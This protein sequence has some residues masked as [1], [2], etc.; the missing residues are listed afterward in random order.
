VIVEILGHKMRWTSGC[1]MVGGEVWSGPE[2]RWCAIKDYEKVQDRFGGEESRYF[3][4]SAN[5]NNT[6]ISPVL[7]TSLA[8]ALCISLAGSIG[9]VHLLLCF[10]WSIHS[11][12]ACQQATHGPPQLSASQGL[13]TPSTFIS[14]RF[15]ILSLK[16][17]GEH[18]PSRS[19]SSTSMAVL[20]PR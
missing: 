13:P 7:C 20:F 9:P 6:T 15:R 16:V 1:G 12:C 3:L 5:N 4:A 10:C 19:S 14:V 18:N 17:G 8:Y 11:T 2:S